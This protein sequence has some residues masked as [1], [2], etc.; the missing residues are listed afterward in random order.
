MQAD[1]GLDTEMK[2]GA[3]RSGVGIF[4]PDVWFHH[5][6]FFGLC[7]C[8]SALSQPATVFD[9]EHTLLIV[10]REASALPVWANCVGG[11]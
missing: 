8:C 6:Y 9:V 2:Y 3:A 7:C 10:I 1:G 11:A 4:Y 5:W